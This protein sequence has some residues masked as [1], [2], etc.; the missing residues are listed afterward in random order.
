MF[1]GLTLDFVMCLVFVKGHVQ[2]CCWS[3]VFQK[4]YTRRLLYG[5]LLQTCMTVQLIFRHTRCFPTMLRRYTVDQLFSKALHAYTVIWY[6]VLKV[7]V[8]PTVVFRHTLWFLKVLRKYIID[9]SPFVT[10]TVTHV[11]CYTVSCFQSVC[12]FIFFWSIWV[13]FQKC[14]SVRT[15]SVFPRHPVCDI[16]NTGGIIFN[17]LI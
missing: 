5:A 2:V 13:V 1:V 3:F 4:C 17:Q 12:C 14:S 15:F 8:G 9:R 6:R 7:Y 11:D 10:Q 16:T